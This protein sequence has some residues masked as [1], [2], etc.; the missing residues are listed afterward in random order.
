MHLS[1]LSSLALMLVLMSTLLHLVA[2]FTRGWVRVGIMLPATYTRPDATYLEH[3]QALDKVPAS[4]SD[5]LAPEAHGGHAHF[6]LLR[7]WMWT[8]CQDL[9][10]LSPPQCQTPGG[11]TWST[12]SRY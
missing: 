12:R 5:W 10:Q 2:M 3:T 11:C 1:V 7:L 8:W 9:Q 4:S 6:L